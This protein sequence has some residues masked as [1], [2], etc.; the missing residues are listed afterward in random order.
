MGAAFVY[1]KRNTKETIVGGALAS[2]PKVLKIVCTP[3]TP[4]A[5]LGKVLHAFK[6]SCVYNTIYKH[7]FR[8]QANELRLRRVPRLKYAACQQ[9]KA[10]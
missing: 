7:T 9:Q 3:L 10:P 2:G 4:N 6:P 8:K 1:V 5:N